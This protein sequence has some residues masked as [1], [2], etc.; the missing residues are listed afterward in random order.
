MGQT[1]QT[2][3]TTI[4]CT[5]TPATDTATLSLCVH[6]PIDVWQRIQYQTDVAQAM[7]DVF[8]MVIL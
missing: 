2:Q 7:R 5:S 8:G 6:G 4:S 3:K 1:G